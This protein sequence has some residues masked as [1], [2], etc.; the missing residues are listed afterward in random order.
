MPFV[1]SMRGWSRLPDPIIPIILIRSV[2]SF[3]MHILSR[4]WVPKTQDTGQSRMLPETHPQS[5]PDDGTNQ[6]HQELK[7]A[8][9]PA[10]RRNGTSIRS[11]WPN[12]HFLKANGT[13]VR[14]WMKLA[15]FLAR[16]GS[17]TNPRSVIVRPSEKNGR[18]TGWFPVH[19]HFQGLYGQ[20][21]GLLDDAHAALRQSGVIVRL[22]GFFVES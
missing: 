13:S 14:Y 1:R 16:D 5:S 11:W 12:S 8:L 9:R 3:Q 6:D 22:R 18:E 15:D 4:G 10:F 20:S 7:A 2:E 21:L 19:L 17:I